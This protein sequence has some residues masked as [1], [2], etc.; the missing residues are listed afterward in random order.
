MLAA[1]SGHPRT[2]SISRQRLL[3][4][5][6]GFDLVVTAKYSSATVRLAILA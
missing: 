1:Q 4:P 3:L 5:V 6:K 2:G